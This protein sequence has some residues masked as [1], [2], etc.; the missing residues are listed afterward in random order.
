LFS[1]IGWAYD[2][3]T[4]SPEMIKKRVVRTGDGSHE[5][6]GWGDRDQ[7]KQDYDSAVIL[8]KKSD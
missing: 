1:K 7:T 6:W 8:N 2:L 4:V 5:I 3:K